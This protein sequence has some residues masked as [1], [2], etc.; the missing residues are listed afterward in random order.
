MAEALNFSTAPA[1][2]QQPPLFFGVR[3]PWDL[4]YFFCPAVAH[5]ASHCASCSAASRFDPNPAAKLSC[6]CVS[7]R[8]ASS[9]LCLPWELDECLWGFFW[10]AEEAELTLAL[11]SCALI[12]TALQEQGG[13]RDVPALAHVVSPVIWDDRVVWC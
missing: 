5:R 3:P 12:S 9:G 6:V 1:D 2:V 11:P 7:C 10:D 8:Y 4:D 13:G